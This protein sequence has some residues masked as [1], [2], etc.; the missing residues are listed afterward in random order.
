MSRI[1]KV[2]VYIDEKLFC[3]SYIDGCSVSDV[4]E[5]LVELGEFNDYK[6]D[7]KEIANCRS[8]TKINR[9]LPKNI[10]YNIKRESKN[11]ILL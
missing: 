10:R 3:H 1:Y 6:I 7:P 9:L 2:E 11:E 8:L 5:Y 4:V